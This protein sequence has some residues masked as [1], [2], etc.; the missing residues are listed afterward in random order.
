MN[1]ICIHTFAAPYMYTMTT[2]ETKLK[3]TP[4]VIF[5]KIVYQNFYFLRSSKNFLII[6]V[7]IKRRVKKNYSC[8][9]SSGRH[10]EN[11][12][13]WEVEGNYMKLVLIFSVFFSFFLFIHLIENHLFFLL[14]WCLLN[15]F[16]L[17][18]ILSHTQA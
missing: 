17:S 18:P 1:N 8:N 10:F 14:C 7:D 2:A 3:H 12:A 4:F 15:T 9:Y 13:I 6:L 5:S 16:I 11:D